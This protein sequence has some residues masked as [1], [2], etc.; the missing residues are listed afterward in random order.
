MKF[1]KFV[2]ALILFGACFSGVAVADSYSITISVFKQS[3][4][5]QPFFENCYGIAVFPTIGK[6]GFWIGGADG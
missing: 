1:S 2:L 6:G 4:A 3:E 5:V